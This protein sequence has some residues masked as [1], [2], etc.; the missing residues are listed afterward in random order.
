NVKY[1]MNMRRI[2]DNWNNIVKEVADLPCTNVVRSVLRRLILATS[3]NYI[4]KERNTRLLSSN[5]MNAQALL[6]NIEENIRLQLQGLT[7]KDSTQVRQVANEWNVKM[8]YHKNIV[9]RLY[10]D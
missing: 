9:G 3:V 5:K 7:V 8:K 6:E 2:P 1:K 10:S 4:W